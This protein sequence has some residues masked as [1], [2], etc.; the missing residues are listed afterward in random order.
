MNALVFLGTAVLVLLSGCGTGSGDPRKAVDPSVDY[1]VLI[2]SQAEQLNAAE[3]G[4]EAAI[5]NFAENL[6]G[7]E[8]KATGPHKDTYDAIYR[9]AQELKQ[10]KEQ[11]AS[12][13][14]LRQKVDEVLSLTAK[15][16][17]ESEPA[18][19]H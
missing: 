7:H 1:A 8:H 15:L 4:I 16:P 9:L 17:S 10:M 18:N 5:D 3:S 13:T 6:E 11:G 14:A 19:T 12:E 2:R